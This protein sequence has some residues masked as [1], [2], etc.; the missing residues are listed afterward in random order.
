MTDDKTKKI[1]VSSLTDEELEA[2]RK[3]SETLDELN[4]SKSIKEDRRNKFNAI[5]QKLK[6]SP[7]DADLEEELDQ[8][9][10]VSKQGHLK[11]LKRTG[12]PLSES[13]L[14]GQ[15]SDAAQQKRFK[16]LE[17]ANKQRL[18]IDD[19]RPSPAKLMGQGDEM[20]ELARDIDLGSYRKQKIMG[21]IA[22]AAEARGASKFSKLAEVMPLKQA[23][24]GATKTGLKAASHIA[25]PL[26]VMMDIADVPEANAGADQIPGRPSFED[27]YGSKETQEQRAARLAAM[28]RFLQK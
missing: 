17:E 13:D 2:L 10:S 1:D 4:L 3:R 7:T 27:L 22:D 18:G 23:L 26:G 21:N 9:K 19:S 20:G 25:L 11:N 6:E 28:N 12:I 24:K 5:M 8:L 15:L 14:S 16:V